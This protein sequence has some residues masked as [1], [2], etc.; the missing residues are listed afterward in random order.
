MVVASVPTLAGGSM[1]EA[2]VLKGGRIAQIVHEN[3]LPVINL[4]QSVSGWGGKHV[5][6]P[7]PKNRRM[8]TNKHFVVGWSKLGTA[9][10]SIS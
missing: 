1:N 9:V 4:T 5:K 6:V 10:Q 3:G 8:V 2:S 7:T